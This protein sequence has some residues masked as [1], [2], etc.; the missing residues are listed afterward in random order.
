MK[1]PPD[2]RPE[3]D[4]FKGILLELAQERS[5]AAVLRLLVDRIVK[6]RLHAPRACVW[7]TEPITRDGG[8]TPQE[9]LDNGTP[10]L[11]LVASARPE[12]T[13]KFE[14]WT[15]AD[16][17]F[18]KVSFHEPLIGR[19]ADSASVRVV[20]DE[21]E[22][23]HYPEWAL[24]EGIVAYSAV[25]MIHK[26]DV[27]GVVAVFLNIPTHD[28]AAEGIQ[29][30][31]LFA[32][33]AAAALV[34]ARA[35]E[36]NERLRRQL[37]LENE[38]LREEVYNTH[39]CGNFVG[40]SAALQKIYQQI[41]LVAPTDAN[42]LILGESG[43]GK[44]LVAREIHEKS[45]RSDRPLIKVNCASIPKDLF[46]SEFFGHVK[47]AFTG[48]LKD[49]QGRFQLAD[50]GTLFLDEVGESPFEL[51]GKLLRVLQE[52]EFERIGEETTR[53]VD[54]RIIAATN[55]NLPGE[56]EAKRFRQDLYFRLSVF[57]IEVAPLRQRV[58]DIPLLAV[59]FMGQTCRRLGIPEIPLKRRHVLQLQN[60][61]WPGNVRELQN[62]IERATIICREGALQFDLPLES[63]DVKSPVSTRS[64]P[65]GDDMGIL[66]YPD[67]ERRERENVLAA[68]EKTKWK[69]SGPGGVAELLGV[70]ATTL[71][72]RMKAMGIRKR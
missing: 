1:L 61:D 19:V 47:G 17:D 10:Y 31:R 68:L 66:T 6:T 13:E 58:E 20:R 53:K 28:Y 55:R 48:A 24:R 14:E 32:D 71:A 65:S 23:E 4:S 72:S 56:V 42:V 11:Y 40:Q 36:D 67:L 37:E 21:K 45:K 54:A 49:R 63:E 44:E 64:P 22:W 2:Y 39:C 5:V 51:Q 34:N 18:R 52:Q 8:S 29:W 57:P 27:L 50:G 70:N 3:F 41:E 25:P 43:T 69:I 33:H 62:I 46:E 26:G 16:G 38:Y 35:F 7:L 9:D 12:G 60:Y 59:H 30:V 15:H